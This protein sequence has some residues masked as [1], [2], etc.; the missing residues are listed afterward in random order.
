M[1]ACL[2]EADRRGFRS[3]RLC[4]IASNAAAFAL[5]HSL[6]FRAVEYMMHCQGLIRTQHQQ[7]LEEERQREGLT[8][9]PMRVEDL[10]ECE[11]LHV[12][13]TSFSR[14]TSLTYAFHAQ[15]GERTRGR[16]DVER[17]STCTDELLH[18]CFVAVDEAGR[19]VGYND[20]H[21]VDSHWIG[22][23]DAVV[24][25]LY[26][27]VCEELRAIGATVLPDVLV[28]TQQH[29]ELLARLAKLGV[30]I[31]RQICLMCKGC[32]VE[33][34]RFVYCPSIMW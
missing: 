31:L 20:G 34:H 2:A 21:D 16:A 28:L 14:L 8:I 32:Y 33:P 6:G 24:V 26:W 1:S 10:P 12:A 30:R 18:T 29:G 3:V 11:R 9:R 7:M 17:E 5:Y 27:R 22:K 19:I 23:K 4:N 13:T 15:R 25:Q